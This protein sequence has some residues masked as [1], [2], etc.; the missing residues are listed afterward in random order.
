MFWLCGTGNNIGHNCTRT[1]IYTSDRMYRAYNRGARPVVSYSSN[2]ISDFDGEGRRSVYRR[3][4]VRSTVAVVRRV[5]G[6]AGKRLIHILIPRRPEPS[7]LSAC[8]EEFNSDKYR[9]APPGHKSKTRKPSG[10]AR[11]GP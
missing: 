2:N 5:A 3:R 4:R 11:A 6:G 7:R 8:R 10:R 1:Y 9:V